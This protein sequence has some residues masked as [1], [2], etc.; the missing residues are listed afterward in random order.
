[1]GGEAE[2]QSQGF[3]VHSVLLVDEETQ[4]TV[5]LIEQQRPNLPV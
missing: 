5:G 3:M 4:H 1:M 2:S